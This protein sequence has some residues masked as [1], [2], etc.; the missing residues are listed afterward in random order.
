MCC[1]S[2]HFMV[3]GLPKASQ[4]K[5]NIHTDFKLHIPFLK[6]TEMGILMPSI[7]NAYRAGV[8][9]HLFFLNDA[10]PHV[11]PCCNRVFPRVLP[12]GTGSDKVQATWTPVTKCGNEPS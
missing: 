4:L 12:P 1:F 7:L 3:F 6:L 11:V 8:L 10:P 2:R 9:F 5:T